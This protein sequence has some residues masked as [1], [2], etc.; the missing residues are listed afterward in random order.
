LEKARMASIEAARAADTAAADH[1]RLSTLSTA[2]TAAV[3]GHRR[4][5]EDA[6]KQHAAL[7]E[8]EEGT[9]HLGRLADLLNVFRNT[10][11]GSVGPTLSAQAA[12]LFAELT[13]REYDRL[14]VDPDTY[15]IQIR[16]A[17]VAYGMDRYSGSETDLANLAL[18]VAISEHVR[19]QS[20]G[21]VGLLVLDEVFGPLDDDRKERM[22]T[23]LERLKGRFRQVLVVTHAS[24]IK[25]QL[26]NALEV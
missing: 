23:A 9:R 10:V 5:L 14:E 21:T 17:G 11:V 24:E 4:R 15:E 18:R 3:D 12:D 22:L 6:D 1:L 20:G 26:P 7:G 19:F 25:E 8:M 13:D 2:A 16:D